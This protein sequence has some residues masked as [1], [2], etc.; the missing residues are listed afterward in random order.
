M[1]KGIALAEANKSGS[2][3]VASGK[4]GRR[5]TSLS[6]VLCRSNVRKPAQYSAHDVDLLLTSLW[7]MFTEHQARR[8]KVAVPWDDSDEP[9]Q[10]AVSELAELLESWL[11]R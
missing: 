5:A 7:N 2:T 8:V 1:G 10:V 4:H 9:V 3:A 6:T 11:D